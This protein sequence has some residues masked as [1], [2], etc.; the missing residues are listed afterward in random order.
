MKPVILITRA[1]EHAVKTAA[2]V[3]EL[4][5]ETLI[6]PMLAIRQLD[7]TDAVSATTGAIILTSRN[8]LPYFK[9]HKVP[10]EIPFFIVGAET[11]KLCSDA[12]TTNIAAIVEQSQDLPKSIMITLKPVSG[13]LVHITSED[14]HTD[15]YDALLD[16]GYGV[17]QKCV[18]KADAAT[19]FSQETQKALNKKRIASVLFYSARTAGIF[20]HLAGA[21]GCLE[22]LKNV[23][24]FC[25]S[26]AIA[27]SLKKPY[28]KAIHVAT[29]PTH[30]AMMDCL[31]LSR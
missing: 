4:G 26:A 5:F 12:G 25:L 10:D 27:E 17:E 7:N 13:S 22:S 24:A 1:A 31:A 8:A 29:S 9:K 15:F 3:A 6:D 30:K 2:D 11:A 23:D 16:A 21:A 20:E 14:A 19:A 28:W 18:Y